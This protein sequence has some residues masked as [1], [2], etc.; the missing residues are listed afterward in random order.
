MSLSSKQTTEPEKVRVRIYR[1]DPETDREPR[2]ESYEVPRTPRMRIMDVLD[3]IHEIKEVDFGYRWLCG[4]KK[5]GTC[6]VNVNGSPKLACWEE[7]EP[8]MTIEPLSNLPLV[9]DLVTSRDPFEAFSFISIIIKVVSLSSKQTT[10]AEQGPGP[11]LPLRSR[12][13]SRAALRILRG[14]AHPAHAHHGRARLRSRDQG[15]GFRLPL[16]LRHEEMRHLRGERQ[17]LAQ[18]RLLGGGGAG[19]DDRAAEQPPARA[20]PGDL[21]RSLRGVPG[22]A[23]P[24][25]RAQA[26]LS[27][28]PG[29]ALGAGHG[30]D[31]ALA[32]LHPMPGLPVGLPGAA[33][34]RQRLCRSG[35][36]GGAERAGPGPAR[37]GR[38]RA[39]RRRGGAG[40][41]V[42]VLL[43]MRARLSDR[44]SDR[45]RGDRAAQASGLPQGR[46]R[47][48]AA[49]A[50]V[51]GRGQGA[52]PRRG[53][54]C[55]AQDQGD[56]P[57]RLT[58]RVPPDACA[59]S[60]AWPTCSR[61]GRRP[62]WR[63]CGR[64]TSPMG[65][66]NE[67]EICVF[68]RLLGQGDVPRARPQHPCGRRLVRT[69]SSRSSR[70]RAAPVRG[71]S[72]R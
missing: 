11:H 63:R 57:E 14:A 72:V 55:S 38:P 49:R 20:R 19:D 42:R 9:R 10:R 52:R 60:S 28:L 69:S 45:R 21:A 3:Y 65:T 71:S 13:R 15:G 70:T 17:R 54:T 61:S 56:Q 64:P 30:A 47:G 27:G 53:G 6:A 67:T 2:Y 33:A 44:D 59:A 58:P 18:A 41:Q 12:D 35:P 46:G 34:A 7:A 4:T 5:C 23:F 16:A 1:F 62:V 37:R 51:L 26:G 8:E 25:R 24:A 43:R 39:A 22:Q 68:S 36:V 31:R 50:R 48:S 66:P 40:L 29:A 32:R